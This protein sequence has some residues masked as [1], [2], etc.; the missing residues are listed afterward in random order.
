M[1]LLQRQG[2]RFLEKVR[3]IAEEIDSLEQVVIVE[4]VEKAPNIAVIEGA[5]FSDWQRERVCH[6]H[7]I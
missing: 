4:V 7:R 1:V 2:A 5:A 3:Q 6:R